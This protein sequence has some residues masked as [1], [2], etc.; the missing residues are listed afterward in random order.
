M[1]EIQGQI[2][3]NLIF[4]S[5]NWII[6][7]Y[8]SNI[9]ISDWVSMKE[10]IQGYRQL[11]KEKTLL[12]YSGNGN[13]DLIAHMIDLVE[14]KLDKVEPSLSIRKKI[15]HVLIEIL[16]NISQHKAEFSLIDYQSFVIYLFKDRNEYLIV[17]GNYIL[18]EKTTKISEWIDH[19]RSLSNLER[20]KVYRKKLTNGEF[21]NRGGA[22][23]GLMDIIRRSE[24]NLCYRVIP[25]D[26]DHSYFVMEVKIRN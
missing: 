6:F 2:K 20:K 1:I 13:D 4:I 3:K 26:A 18:N 15:I 21:T 8:L 24:G 25:A 19:Y 16:Q 11:Y 14:G 17:S 10:I 23:L 22:G 12:S 9:I 7:K 5:K